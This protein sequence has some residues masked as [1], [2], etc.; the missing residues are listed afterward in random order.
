M[1][2]DTAAKDTVGTLSFEQALAEL[3][4]IVNQL[5]AGTVELEDSISLYQRGDQLKRHCQSKLEAARAKIEK[6]QLSA[7]GAAAGVTD[8]DAE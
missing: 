8:F 3:E 2:S 4:A 1:P 7:D 5:E 6:I